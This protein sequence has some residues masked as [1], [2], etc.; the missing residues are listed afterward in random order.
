[1]LG[2]NLVSLS[3]WSPGSRSHVLVKPSYAFGN[4]ILCSPRW[5]FNSRTASGWFLAFLSEEIPEVNTDPAQNVKNQGT[6]LDTGYR[7]LDDSVWNKCS[8]SGSIR[9]LFF[10]LNFFYNSDRKKNTYSEVLRAP[11]CREHTLT[12]YPGKVPWHKRKGALWCLM[13]HFTTMKKRPFLVGGDRQ[14]CHSTDEIPDTTQCMSD[15]QLLSWQE[16]EKCLLSPM[17]LQRF[18]KQYSPR[19]WRGYDCHTPRFFSAFWVWERRSLCLHT[20]QFSHQ[21]TSP[22][23]KISSI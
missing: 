17:W 1:M 10:T 3:S 7:C 8:H 12:Q 9:F 22:V 18:S 14:G 19:E 13:S 2:R 16:P 11:Q 23:L 20:K 5:A 6:S 4:C 21:T 15:H